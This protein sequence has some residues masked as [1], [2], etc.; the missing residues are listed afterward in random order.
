MQGI[1][2]EDQ[3]VFLDGILKEELNE[4]KLEFSSSMKGR[5]EGL[6]KM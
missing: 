3:G 2:G 6:N 1:G 5:K 4:V